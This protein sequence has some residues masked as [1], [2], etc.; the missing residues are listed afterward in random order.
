MDLWHV[1]AAAILEAATPSLMGNGWQVT[2]S[3]SKEITTWAGKLSVCPPSVQVEEVQRE[4]FSCSVGGMGCPLLGGSCAPQSLCQRHHLLQHNCSHWI[5]T[6]SKALIFWTYKN[7][8][9]CYA[10]KMISFQMIKLF[11]W[12]LQYWGSPQKQRCYSQRQPCANVHNLGPL[13]P[14]S[15]LTT[16]QKR[17]CVWILLW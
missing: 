11:Q 6:F 7:V 13:H 9:I 17:S 10:C 4:A 8:I 14:A 16:I 1:E 12:K 5:M 2:A 15:R 3:L